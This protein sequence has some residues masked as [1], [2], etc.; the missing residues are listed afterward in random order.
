MVYLYIGIFITKYRLF[1][2]LNCFVPDFLKW[3]L[4]SLGLVGIIVPNRGLSQVKT[5]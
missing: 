5:K 3:T 2:I 1:T 4:P